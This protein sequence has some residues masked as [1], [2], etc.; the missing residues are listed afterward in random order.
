MPCYNEQAAIETVI[1]TWFA[2]LDSTLPDFTLLALNDGSTDHTEAILTSLAGELGP[3]LKI[4]T[5]ANLGHGQT[6][7]KG[8]RIA[9]EHHI[10]H[11]LQIDSDGQSDP[12]HFSEFWEKRQDHHVIYGKRSRHDGTRRIIASTILRLLLRL[13]A[14]ADCVDANVPYRLMDTRACAKSI[15][16]IPSD[17]FLANVALAVALRRTPH[18]THGEIP[19]TFPARI[20]GE[21]SVPFSKFTQ[22]A[23]Q[24]FRQL[25]HANLS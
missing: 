13:L 5:H 11:I 10:P 19:I 23:L 12:S 4:I 24:L 21:P 17:F 25:K 14:K 2:A 6:C 22:K 1:R 8:Y 3:R 18:I 20:G 15:L 7:L 9:I 16:S